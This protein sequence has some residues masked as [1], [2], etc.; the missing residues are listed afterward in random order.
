[1]AHGKVMF[2][3]CTNKGSTL[4]KL[5]SKLYSFMPQSVVL[6][7]SVYRNTVDFV[8]I[9]FFFLGD[10]I[11]PCQ[12]DARHAPL[13]FEQKCCCFLLFLVICEENNSSQDDR[14]VQRSGGQADVQLEGHQKGASRSV[15]NPGFQMRVSTEHQIFAVS[16][17][18]SKETSKI[19][20]LSV[21]VCVCV[22]FLSCHQV[23]AGR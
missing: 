18:W 6:C 17:N 20:L 13:H 10:L 3:A 21:C 5:F 16:L 2:D 9:E 4:T 22:Y 14:S 7:V 15:E 12:L 23:T 8:K 1:M 19:P 11:F